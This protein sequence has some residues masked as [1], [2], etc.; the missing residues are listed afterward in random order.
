MA[1]GAFVSTHGWEAFRSQELI[2]LR[3]A[4]APATGGRILACGGGVVETP[5]AVAILEEW[6]EGG[7]CVVW[8]DRPIDDIVAEFGEGGGRVYPAGM[9]EEKL[10]STFAARQPLYRACCSHAFAVPQAAVAES[11]A[12]LAAWLLAEL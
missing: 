11:V 7:G 9:D 2:T 5:D 4:L 10:R 3:T 12:A 6:R 1:R 8:L